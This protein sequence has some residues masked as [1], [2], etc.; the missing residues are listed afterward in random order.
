MHAFTRIGITKHGGWFTYDVDSNAGDEL[1]AL[2]FRRDRE[3]L[4]LRDDPRL[5]H[6]RVS[7]GRARVCVCVC[8]CARVCGRLRARARVRIDRG[9]R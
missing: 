6:E 5:L 1:C 8:V 7:P 2:P 9:R 4:L 3:L